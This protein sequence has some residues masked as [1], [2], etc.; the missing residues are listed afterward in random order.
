MD[1]VH[2]KRIATMKRRKL[3]EEAKRAQ[4]Q[5][6]KALTRLFGEHVPIR[7]SWSKETPETESPSQQ[8]A[9]AQDG[10]EPVDLL[11]VIPDKFMGD[12][13]DDDDDWEPE[14]GASRVSSPPSLPQNDQGIKTPAVY[15]K[16]Q[17]TKPSSVHQNEQRTKEEGIAEL[18][19]Q[20]PRPSD[21]PPA[22]KTT[23][24]GRLYTQYRSKSLLRSEL[25]M[26]C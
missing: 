1:H 24:S 5:D 23:A 19:N 6:P 21:V 8:E 20:A 15:Q 13:D 25:A 26:F 2:A 7:R 10:D 16:V 3:E 12:D 18:V 11:P 14:S 17:R 9:P 22:L 4:A